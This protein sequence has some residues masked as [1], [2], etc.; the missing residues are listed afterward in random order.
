V[1]RPRRPS[2][3]TFRYTA[4][5][6]P[7]GLLAGKNKKVLAI[8]A[9]GG[10][11]SESSGLSALDHQVPYLRFIFGFIGVTD[12]RFVQAG[13]TGAIVQGRVSAAEFLS[14]HLKEVASAI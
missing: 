5:G 11:Y 10:S 1:G 2:R 13:G 7:E 12:V 14:P 4:G 8:V 6:K 3:E 9:S